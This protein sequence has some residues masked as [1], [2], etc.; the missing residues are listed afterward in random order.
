MGTLSSPLLLGVPPPVS[1]TAT[2]AAKLFASLP[3]DPHLDKH[4][5]GLR[6]AG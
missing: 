4:A 5:A 1:S 3:H 2:V 6:P